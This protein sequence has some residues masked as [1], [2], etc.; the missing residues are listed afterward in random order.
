MLANLRYLAPLA[1]LAALLGGCGDD[2]GNAETPLPRTFAVG[3]ELS[4]LEPGATLALDNNGG[5]RLTLTANGSFSFATAVAEGAAYSVTVATLPAGEACSVTNGSGR[6]G[7]A[8]VTDV[9]V[10]CALTP[11]GF[12]SAA[13]SM[14]VARNA[15]SATLLANGKLLLAGSY[16]SGT[17]STAEIYDPATDAWQMTGNMTLGRA[18]HSATLLAN[19]KVLVAGGGNDGIG[20][21]YTATAELYDPQTGQW[22]PTGSL[23][24]TRGDHQAVRLPDG[25]VLVSGGHGSAFSGPNEI[26]DPAT[27]AWSSAGNPM[28]NR[29]SSTATLLGNG[30]VLIVGGWNGGP[31]R[32]AEIY[33]PATNTSSPA[34]IPT[35]ARYYHVAQLL[36]DGKVLVA[37]G[38]QSGS[39]FTFAGA[40]LYDPATNTWSPTGP[41][42]FG[43]WVQVATPIADGR[44]LVTGGAS[45]LYDHATNLWTATGNPAQGRY[46]ATVT[47]LGN[48]KVVLAGGIVSSAATSNVEFYW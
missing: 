26:Y 15:H 2:G 32:S 18:F 42:A 39:P 4:G 33:D 38:L 31:L 25:R 47:L 11:R 8:P 17:A 37:G 7:A 46:S 28:I 44:V 10:S 36:A 27:G 29:V 5:D 6:V 13:P 16:V 12:F 41:M 40:E 1:L 34:A 9:A 30:K 22:T 21:Y 45:Q 20:G 43:F 35:T 3:G 23:A 14:Q 19:G 24:R 48:R